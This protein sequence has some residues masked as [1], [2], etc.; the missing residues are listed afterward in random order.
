MKKL[1]FIIFIFTTLCLNA[2]ITNTP[3]AGKPM[4]DFPWFQYINN[5]QTGDT[6]YL[7]IDPNYFPN[8]INQTISVFIIESKTYNSGKRNHFENIH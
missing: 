2:Q 1:Y 6:V 5:F 3:L 7:G 4:N 8:L